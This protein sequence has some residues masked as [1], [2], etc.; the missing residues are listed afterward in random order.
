MEAC[1]W[2]WGAIATLIGAGIASTTAWC[3]SNEWRNQKVSEVIAN[4]T[5]E[6]IYNLSK[7]ELIQNEI[8]T[9]STTA[10]RRKELLEEYILYKNKASK[11]SNFLGKACSKDL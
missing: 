11:H 7:L 1:N 6:Y 5:K 2:H 8:E 3:I 10:K 4:E 9:K